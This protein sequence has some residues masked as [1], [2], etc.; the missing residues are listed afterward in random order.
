MKKIIV[1]LGINLMFLYMGYVYASAIEHPRF[2][3]GVLKDDAW[4]VI[5][6]ERKIPIPFVDLY[7]KVRINDYGIL[8]DANQYII[9]ACCDRVIF[10]E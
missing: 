3:G 7:W 1:F 8:N 10:C 2:I 9:N 4:L 6:I 5:K